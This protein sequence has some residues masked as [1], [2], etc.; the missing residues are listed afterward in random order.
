MNRFVADHFP[1]K[2][3]EFEEGTPKYND[4]INALNK[5]SSMF[6]IFTLSESR[7]F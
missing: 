5:V 1:L 4:Y 3:N 7:K 2:S 6:A